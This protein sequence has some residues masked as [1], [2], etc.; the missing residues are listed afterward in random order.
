MKT[1]K[2]LRAP[3]STT[4]TVSLKIQLRD[5]IDAA[6]KAVQRSRSNYIAKVLTDAVIASE[7]QVEAQ[8]ASGSGSKK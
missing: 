8:S 6:A 3:D 5:R 7:A 2:R 1:Q 4:I